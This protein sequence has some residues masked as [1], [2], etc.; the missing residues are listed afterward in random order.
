[1]ASALVCNLNPVVGRDP[2]A[3]L[4]PAGHRGNLPPLVGIFPDTTAPIV[5][6]AA[7]A[8]RERALMLCGF[9]PPPSVDTGPV[10]NGQNLKRG[11]WRLV[12]ARA[13]AY[14]MKTETG[15]DPC[16]GIPLVAPPGKGIIIAAGRN[17]RSFRSRST[18]SHLAF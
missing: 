2:P 17:G 12:E 16:S 18:A 5:Q 11:N 7:D 1:L 9:P 15:R 6:T 10:T 3:R 13:V 14:S 8:V 4:R